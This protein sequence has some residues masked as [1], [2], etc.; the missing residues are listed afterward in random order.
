MTTQR[1]MSVMR[2]PFAGRGINGYAIG[3]EVFAKRI[4]VVH[5]V[6]KVAKIAP[7]SVLFRIPV[8]G[9]LDHRRPVFSGTCLVFRRSQENQGKPAFVATLATDFNH[10]QQIAKEMQRVFQITH[11][12]HGVKILHVASFRS[13][14]N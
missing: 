11:P 9:E 4:K 10:S 8:I 7:A 14:V 1:P 12:D 6:S 3:F 13:E 2:T 5:P